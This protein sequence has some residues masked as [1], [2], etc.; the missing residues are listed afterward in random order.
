MQR[1]FSSSLALSLVL[2]LGCQNKQ[3]HKFPHTMLHLE[4]LAPGRVRLRSP[5]SASWIWGGR[6]QQQQH[7]AA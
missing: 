7:D 5:P 6:V 1:L 4:P 2:S 3:D